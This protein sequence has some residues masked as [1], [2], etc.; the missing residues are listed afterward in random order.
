MKTLLSILFILAMATSAF[1]YNWVTCPLNG[2]Q[3]TITTSPDLSWNQAEAEAVSLGGHLVTIRDASE[4]QWLKDTF[5]TYWYWIGLNDVAIEGTF[6]WTSGEPLDYTNW[7][8]GEPSNTNNEDFVGFNIADATRG[9]NDFPDWYRMYGIIEIIPSV[10]P[11]D[12]ADGDVDGL[13]AAI[14]YANSTPWPDTINLATNGTYTLTKVHNNNQG[15]NGLPTIFTDITINGNSSIIKR[16]SISDTPLFR[17]FFITGPNEGKLTLN[18]VDIQNGQCANGGGAFQNMNGVVVL[19]NCDLTQ[20][21]DSFFGGAFYNRG[22]YAELHANRSSLSDNSSRLRGGAIYNLDGIVTL[23]GCLLSH[24]NS[25]AGGAINNRNARLNIINTTFSG[26]IAQDNS[27]TTGSIGGGIVNTD[28]QINVFSSTFANNSDVD[29]Y[30]GGICNLSGSVNLKN[31]IV[32]YNTNNDCHGIITSL[33]HN[34]V[35]DNSANIS[36]TGDMNNTDPILDALADNGGPTKT[37]A[38]LT[39]SPAIDVIP[40]VD[41]IDY[42]GNQLT[43]DQRGIARPQNANCDIGSFE[44]IIA[45]VCITGTVSL[46]DY[47]GDITKVPIE[48]QLRKKGGNTTTQTIHLDSGGWFEIKDVPVGTYDISFKASHWLRDTLFNVTV[49]A[50]IADITIILINGDVDG[51]NDIDATD[52]NAFKG[53]KQLRPDTDLNGDGKENGHDMKIVRDNLGSV[54]DQ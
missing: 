44:A 30:G 52:L 49:S 46:L 14:N 36:E 45:K 8:P 7:N 12:I 54:G 41:C 28:G 33:G 42:E 3:Y 16:S 31:S 21:Y 40:V 51:D 34:I 48:V 37:H 47:Q 1:A 32:A 39:G 19:N 22:Y 5:G 29:G 6:V 25:P 17:I 26:N 9:W 2:H 20:N 23:N 18:N 53:K 35:S 38:L 27:S 43:A 13:I 11:L 4:E 24:N 50:N 10:A 15:P